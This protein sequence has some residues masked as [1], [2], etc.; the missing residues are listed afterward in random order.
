M[1]YSCDKCGET[2]QSCSKCSMKDA[3]CCVRCS[4]QLLL[5]QDVIICQNCLQKYTCP[6]HDCMNL[7]GNCPKGYH[8]EL[9]TCPDGRI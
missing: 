4:D 8:H 7:R 1:N 2:R 5:H 9:D 3:S 6:V